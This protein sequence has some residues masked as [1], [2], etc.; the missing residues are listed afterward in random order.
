TLNGAT[1]AIPGGLTGLTNQSPIMADGTGT[2]SAQV[3][4]TDPSQCNGGSAPNMNDLHFS[5]TNATVAGL[6]TTANSLGNIFVADILCGPT[7]TGCAGFTGPVDYSYSA[8]PGPI[9][10]AGFPGL[11]AACGGLLALQRRRRRRAQ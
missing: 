7:V 3:F 8:V 9:A 4:C 11:I 6:S 1:V 5:V 10:G 2:W